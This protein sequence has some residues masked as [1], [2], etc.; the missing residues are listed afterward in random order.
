MYTHCKIDCPVSAAHM[1][2]LPT[3]YKNNDWAQTLFQES[4]DTYNNPPAH[5]LLFIHCSSLFPAEDFWMISST[6][7]NNVCPVKRDEFA[8]LWE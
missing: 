5:L 6:Q 4:I 1:A 2:F 7:C 8:P 3:T